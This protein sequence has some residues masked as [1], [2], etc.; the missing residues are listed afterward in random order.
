MDKLEVALTA[1]CSL[2]CWDPIKSQRLGLYLKCNEILSNCPCPA[3]S[4]LSP[5]LR[6]IMQRKLGNSAPPLQISQA[7]QNQIIKNSQKSKRNNDKGNSL[8]ET[9]REV[10]YEDVIESDETGSFIKQA[11]NASIE[12]IPEQK[13]E[14]IEE[15]EEQKTAK[16]KNENI[17]NQVSSSMNGTIEVKEG[18]GNL[19]NQLSE[20]LEN[21][22]P[23]TK[24]NSATPTPPPQN[25]P[26]MP[27]KRHLHSTKLSQDIQ[28][29]GSINGLNSAQLMQILVSAIEGI[30]TEAANGMD[31]FG[32]KI[33]LLTEEITKYKNEVFLIRNYAQK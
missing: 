33:V 29:V 27:A 1:N 10:S 16:S 14:E 9:I 18:T 17:E 6:E 13:N 32:K 4:E 31:E 28:K 7:Q 15:Q 11:K 26:E 3:P 30:E 12:K 25:E 23:H 24:P 19:G 21:M 22:A 20:I 2:I 5:E 8:M